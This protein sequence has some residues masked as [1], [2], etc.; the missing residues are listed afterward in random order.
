MTGEASWRLRAAR[1]ADAMLERFQR[2]DGRLIPF[3][4]SGGLALVLAE[5]G[6]LDAPSGT[7]APVKIRAA[8]PASSD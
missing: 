1:L 3:P 4:A 7:S 6:D 8:V 5:D 2:P